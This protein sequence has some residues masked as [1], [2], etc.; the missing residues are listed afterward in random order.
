M[1]L[2]ATAPSVF[3]AGVYRQVLSTK[4]AR[5]YKCTPCSCSLWLLFLLAGGAAI[6]DNTYH[7]TDQLLALEVAAGLTPPSPPMEGFLPLETWRD[8]LRNCLQKG[9][10]AGPSPTTAQ[11]REDIVSLL[12]LSLNLTCVCLLHF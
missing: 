2:C 7:Y 10:P 5:I 12:S 4:I 9:S 6:H 1:Y 3:P 11:A 8:F